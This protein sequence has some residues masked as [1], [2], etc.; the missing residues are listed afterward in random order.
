MAK[1]GIDIFTKWM[2]QEL[3]SKHL[4]KT[5]MNAIAPGFFIG[6]QNRKLLTNE[7][8]SFTPERTAF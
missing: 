6:I 4:H 7:D 2:A 1:A 8:G 5:R 3:A